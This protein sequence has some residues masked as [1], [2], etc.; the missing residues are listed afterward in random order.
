MYI[1]IERDPRS[2]GF[3]WAFFATALVALTAKITFTCIYTFIYL[4]DLY[5]IHL[6]LVVAFKLKIKS[7]VLC[8]E[9]SRTG[10]NGMKCSLVCQFHFSFQGGGGG[11]FR[12]LNM[13]VFTTCS[14][15]HESFEMESPSHPEVKKAEL[16]TKIINKSA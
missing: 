4:Y 9:M 11:G 3:F 1:T 8:P 10:I 7:A 12:Y 13:S 5:H 15:F 14:V 16:I 2:Y 6:N